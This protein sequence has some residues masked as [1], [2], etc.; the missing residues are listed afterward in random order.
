MKGE[1]KARAHTISRA[2]KLKVLVKGVARKSHRT[3]ARQAIAHI[4]VRLNVLNI[5]RDDLK[6][7]MR[8][9]CRKSTNFMLRASTAEALSNFSWE[10]LALELEKNAP[11]FFAILTACVEVRQPKKPTVS[12]HSQKRTRRASNTAVLGVC[13]AIL[14]RHCNHHM[15]LVQRLIS[16]ILHSGHSAKQVCL[17]I[18]KL[19]LKI[20]I[21]DSTCY[22]CSLPEISLIV[23]RIFHPQYIQVV[24]CP[25]GIKVCTYLVQC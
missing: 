16:L 17:F 11:T 13:A 15:N 7:E 21:W 1:R 24:I 9:L 23:T 19:L 2:S 10:V 14:L 5:I 6:R 20:H 3:V 12:T 8:L 4:T 18:L 22:K 25:K